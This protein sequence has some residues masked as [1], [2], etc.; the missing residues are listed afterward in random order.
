MQDTV[1]E[2]MSPREW[3][4]IAGAINAIVWILVFI[5]YRIKRSRWGL[6]HTILLLYSSIAVSSLHLFIYYPFSDQMFEEITILPY[7]YLFVMIMLPLYPI[8]KLES[9]LIYSIR[10]PRKTLFYLV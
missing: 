3:S 1:W 5:Y 4:Y 7:I 9:N 8:I 2:I 6:T 10:K